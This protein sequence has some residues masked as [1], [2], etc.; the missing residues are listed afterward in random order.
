MYTMRN[1]TQQLATERLGQMSIYKAQRIV[2]E[3]YPD[4]TDRDM[5][6]SLVYMIMDR[7]Y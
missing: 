6:E 3:E 4:I 2:S 1:I 7:G 5:I